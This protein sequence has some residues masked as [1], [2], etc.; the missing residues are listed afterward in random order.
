M[1]DLS[2]F[3]FFFFS[4]DQIVMLFSYEN[5]KEIVINFFPAFEPYFHYRLGTISHETGDWG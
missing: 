2:F 5:R 1:T 3:L 4:P